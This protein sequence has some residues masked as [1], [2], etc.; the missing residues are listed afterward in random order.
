MYTHNNELNV[1]KLIEYNHT[2]NSNR[3]LKYRQTSAC[4]FGILTIINFIARY[5]GKE[6]D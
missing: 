4:T 5:L 2:K 1:I 3:Y 6:R